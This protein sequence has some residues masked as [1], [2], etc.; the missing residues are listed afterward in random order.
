[1]LVLTP[2][3]PDNGDRSAHDCQKGHVSQR[4]ASHTEAGRPHRYNGGNGLSLPQSGDLGIKRSDLGV[5]GSCERLEM[6][7]IALCQEVLDG[8]IERR[9][10]TVILQS[11][12]IGTVALPERAVLLAQRRDCLFQQGRTGFDQPSAVHV[13]GVLMRVLRLLLLLL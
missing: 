10:F 5:V 13:D 2:G 7:G 11:G 12:L 3:T 6:F 4:L 8:D 1:M 9:P